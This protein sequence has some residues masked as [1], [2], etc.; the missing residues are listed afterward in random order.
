[1]ML[2]VVLCNLGWLIASLAVAQDFSLVPGVVVN[3]SPKSS[4][5][6]VGSPSIVILPNGDYV[7][8]HDLFG[9]NSNQGSSPTSKIF[10]STDRGQTWSHAADLNGQFWSNLFVY[11]ND[12]YLMGTSKEYGK[13][14]IRKSTDGGTTWT[15]PSTSATGQLTPVDGYH[16]AP[17]PMT[18]YGGRIWRGFEDI[19]AGGGW[20]PQFR[21]FVMSAPIGSDLLN[22]ANWTVTNSLPG[23]Q[24]WLGGT[25]GGWL[26]GNV[27]VTPDDKLINILRVDERQYAAVVDINPATQTSTFDV[28]S[29]FIDYPGGEKKFQI[30]YDSQSQKYWALSSPTLPQ[31]VGDPTQRNALGVMSSKDL[32]TW[33]TEAIV[34]YHP[35]TVNHA[36]QY[37]D[38]QFDGNDLIVASRTAYDDGLGGAARAHDANFLTFHRINNFRDLKPKHVLVA[39]ANSDRVLRYQTLAGESWVPFGTFASGSYAG[40]PLD[41]PFGLISDDDG[42]VY[43]GEQKDGGRIL[44]FDAAGNF[45]DVV[46]KDGVNFTGRPEALISGPN[47]T[48]LL[49]VAFGTSSDRI[50]KIDPTS[51]TTSL[52][53]DT[54]FAGGTLNN[55]RAMAIGPDGNL[56]VADRE[57]DRIRKFDATTGAFLGNFWSGDHPQGLVWDEV[58][59]KFFATTLA[60]TELIEISPNGDTS[61]V[62][63]T[64]DLGISPGMTTVGGSVFWSDFQNGNINE[65]TGNNQKRTVVTGL[66]GPGHL[67]SVDQPR[68]RTWTL[69]AAGSWENVD[70][71]QV[72]WGVPNSTEEIA[73]F[74]NAISTSR[75]VILDQNETVAGLRFASTHAYALAGAGNLTIDDADERAEIDVVSG[76]HQLQVEVDLGSDVQVKVNQNAAI[77]FQNVLRLHGHDLHK[78][79]AGTLTING[80][81]D[82][83]G[84]QVVLG[85]GSLAGNGAIAG[86][87]ANEGGTVSPG[88]SPGRLSIEGDFWQ[89]STGTLQIEIAGTEAGR[90]DVLDVA[91][92]FHA[93]GT[94]Q[95]LLVD[96]FQPSL[97]DQFQVLH[98]ARA[99]SEFD[100]VRLPDLKSGL[101][102]DTSKLLEPGGG[103][104]S[105]VAVPV[106][107]VGTCALLLPCYFVFCPTYSSSHQRRQCDLRNIST[108]PTIR[109][110]L[111]T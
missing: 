59:Q 22:A 36:F 20:G 13:V 17:V 16:T 1:M 102:W 39:D 94:V 58:N 87:F 26:E 60:T 43:V 11:Q 96:G 28:E 7:A 91:Q 40:A 75:T 4:G 42:Y 79:G 110:E 51:N 82:T 12:L 70:H 106:P 9:P 105:V 73:V 29:G 103:F 27:V 63:S 31:H 45:L 84:G 21:S 2:R 64:H 5:K 41:L 53:V 56:Y 25:F 71:W 44:R 37:P 89:G 3:H 54:S 19:F 24:Q 81:L 92:E 85:A 104:V 98:F 83:G 90:F 47:N 74:G 66:N 32:R 111:I 88:N 77:T 52:L 57:N 14:I 80:S 108:V 109:W 69:N 34:L 86:G 107:E 101:A 8:S 99:V 100:L 65:L 93:G 48:L 10:R 61:T 67:L 23:N 97:G 76:N 78:V 33:S 6:Y 49:S 30:R 95:F 18:I 38:W 55:P 68:E 62:Y 46:A 72:F 50:Y 15:T 35:D